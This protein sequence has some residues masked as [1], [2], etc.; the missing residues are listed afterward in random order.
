MVTIGA[1]ACIT[2][3]NYRGETAERNVTPK[4]VW[5]GISEWHPV[6]QWFMTVFDH[7][8]NADRDFA[9]KDLGYPAASPAQSHKHDFDCS[10]TLSQQDESCPVGY[11][12]L[13]CDICD[14]KGVVPS[15]RA[16]A[17]EEVRAIAEKQKA[18]WFEKQKGLK[19]LEEAYSEDGESYTPLG[20]HEAWKSG[21]ANGHFSEADWFLQTIER[22]LTQPAVREQVL[23]PDWVHIAKMA[24]K[25]GIRYQTNQSFID[26]LKAISAI[27]EAK[28]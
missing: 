28:P 23:E 16:Q 24:G 2:Y 17:L 19:C 27:L 22:L 1:P 21:S 14:G 10:C 20:D 26:F 13:L 4:R 8:K 9:L 5:Y 25:F 3:T 6:P 15:P 7:E 11:P 18:Y 12:S